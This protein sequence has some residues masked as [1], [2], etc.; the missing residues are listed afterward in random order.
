MLCL[1]KKAG[2]EMVLMEEFQTAVEPGGV[3]FMSKIPF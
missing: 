1:V 2:T 3:R